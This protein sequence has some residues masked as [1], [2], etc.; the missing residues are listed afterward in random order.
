[1]CKDSVLNK[2]FFG[3]IQPYEEAVDR[4][5]YSEITE[6]LEY[7]R[8]IL[9]GEDYEKL[10]HLLALDA[11]EIASEAPERFACGFKLGFKLAMEIFE[12]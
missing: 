12:R 3:E 6:L 7:F 11:G 8:K 1:M 4:E 9:S 5:H 10:D 2:L